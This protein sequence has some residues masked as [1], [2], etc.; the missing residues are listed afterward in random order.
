MLKNNREK[1]LLSVTLSVLVFIVIAVIIGGWP[2][3]NV[4]ANGTEEIKQAV[5]AYYEKMPD[6][7]YKIPEPE[8]K[9]LVDSK[10]TNIYILDIR[11][12]KDFVK[13]HIEGA[14]NIPFKE[15][16]SSLSKLPKDKQI[17]VY[18]YT[19]QTGGQ[20]TSL[21]NVAGFRA[22]SLNGGMNN[23][24]AKAGYPVVAGK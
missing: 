18:C 15:V 22:K 10:D 23:G 14:K 2:S 6:N 7:S 11:D 21:L 19:G 12:N 13:G 3:A 4:S 9:K 17:I 24:W 5:V 16:G 8:L 20:T 1:S